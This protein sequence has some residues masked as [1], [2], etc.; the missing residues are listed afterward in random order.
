M[1]II[2][3]IESLRGHS[4]DKIFFTEYIMYLSAV[5][6]VLSNS[7]SATYIDIAIASILTSSSFYVGRIF[8]T[9][10]NK[11]TSSSFNIIWC[12]SRLFTIINFLAL[13]LFV[14]N[15]G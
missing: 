15:F 10:Y 4:L 3:R 14:H 2:W 6:L 1:G 13:M 12:I 7:T 9:Q 8:C 11:I 5:Y